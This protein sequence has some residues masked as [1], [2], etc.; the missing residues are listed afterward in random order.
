MIIRDHL[1]LLELS[2]TF[3]T[4]AKQDTCHI[5]LNLSSST[6]G[7]KFL[8]L[9]LE[10]GFWEVCPIFAP[11]T[12]EVSTESGSAPCLSDKNAQKILNL[13]SKISAEYQANSQ[14]YSVFRYS[15]IAELLLNLINV[16]EESVPAPSHTSVIPEIIHFLEAN[17]TQKISIDMLAEKFYISK[18][19]LMRQFKK[20]TGSTIHNFILNKRIAQAC[21]LIKRQI[22]PSEACYLS[23]FT[24]YSLF[25]KS[26]TKITGLS[27]SQYSEN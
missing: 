18:Y 12:I 5:I 7:Q 4:S 1:F 20:E 15:W 23:G 17:Y 25:F 24:D 22:T 11:K 21:N 16:P 19:H 26:F 14:A 2:D 8:Y 9:S 27:P 3:S 13:F 6:A 10:P